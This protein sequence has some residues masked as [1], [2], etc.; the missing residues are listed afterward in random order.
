MQHILAKE[1]ELQIQVGES[2][3]QR[4]EWAKQ[5]KQVTNEYERIRVNLDETETTNKTFFSHDLLKENLAF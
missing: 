4:Q 2:E 5:E 1:G 3:L